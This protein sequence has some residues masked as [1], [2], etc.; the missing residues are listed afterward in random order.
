M[1][2]ITATVHDSMDYALRMFLKHTSYSNEEQSRGWRKLLL[3]AEVVCLTTLKVCNI[4]TQSCM[5]NAPHRLTR[6]SASAPPKDD[7]VSH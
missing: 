2:Q 1:I 6:P 4:L 3:H 7:V 5:Y